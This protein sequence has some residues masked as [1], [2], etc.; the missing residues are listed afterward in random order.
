M[1]A[2]VKSFV[3]AE[4]AKVRRRSIVTEELNNEWSKHIDPESG[5]E[6]YHNE[7]TGVSQY[8]KPNDVETGVKSF[9]QAEFKKVRRRSIVTEDNLKIY[10]QIL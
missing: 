5:K 8:G 7:S 4:F 6:F 2:N 10:E 3:Q 9:V 1:L